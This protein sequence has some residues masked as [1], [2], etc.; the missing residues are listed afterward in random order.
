MIRPDV[1]VDALG[2][3]APFFAGVP[4]SLLKHFGTHLAGALSPNQHVIA[5]N[6]GAAVGLAIGHHLRTGEV[7]VVYLQNSGIGNAV[8]PLLSLADSEVYGIP[9]VLVIG[10]RGQPGVKDEPQHVKQGRVMTSLLHAMEIPF[11]VLPREEN[12][13]LTAARQARADAVSTSGPV[14]ILVEAG[15]FEAAEAKPLPATTAPGLPS[16]EE[17]LVAF[18]EAV[19]QTASVVCTT[20]MLG[21]EMFEYREQHPSTAVRDF[22]CVGGMGHAASIAQGIALADPTTDTWVFDGDG[23]L[24]MHQGSLAVAAKS[25]RPNLFHVVFNNGV[26][27]SV[28]GQPTAIDQVDIPAL[29]LACG[30]RGSATV[31]TCEAAESA[32]T[33]AR[34]TGGPYLIE[35]QVHPGN[36]EGIGRPTRTPQNNKEAFMAALREDA[37]QP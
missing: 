34:A 30:Y 28:G 19:G 29:A 20:G 23:A 31:H 9:L 5:A 14:A 12:D 24:L 37:A 7:P 35:V 32:V 22:L 1:F 18:A 17:A 25:A 21:R 4:D 27:D 33:A 6:E 36:R 16:R 11:I 2:G 15:T 8:N 26:H 3:P 13:A 10:W